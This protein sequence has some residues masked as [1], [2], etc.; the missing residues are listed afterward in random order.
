MFIRPTRR[1]HSTSSQPGPGL[2][3]ALLWER[4]DRP[5][6]SVVTSEIAINKAIA[7]DA[8]IT[9]SRGR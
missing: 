3:H 6:G 5:V 4:K 8:I 9:N 1:L 7:S 2:S